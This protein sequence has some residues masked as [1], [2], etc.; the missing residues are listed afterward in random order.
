RLISCSPLRPADTEL[1][2]AMTVARLMAA[3]LRRGRPS[4]TFRSGTRK[5]PPPMP[6]SAPT[7]PAAAPETKTIAARANETTGI[8]SDYPA[9]R[10]APA[11]L[12]DFRDDFFLPLRQILRVRE[13]LHGFGAVGGDGSELVVMLGHLQHFD[14][15]QFA[16]ALEPPEHLGGCLGPASGRL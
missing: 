10:S 8:G 4:A 11:I 14:A 2:V 9:V 15:E 5:T 7:L 3:A 6:R 1:D 13:R 16:L 12:R